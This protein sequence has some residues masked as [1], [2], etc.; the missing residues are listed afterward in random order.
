MVSNAQGC[1][2][3]VSMAEQA[4]NRP[5]P[6]AGCVQSRCECALLSTWSRGRG[7]EVFACDTDLAMHLL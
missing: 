5:H 3:N 7:Y 6:V 4:L 2:L 1:S